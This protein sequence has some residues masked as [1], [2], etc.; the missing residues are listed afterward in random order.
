[1]TIDKRDER[2][3]KI[4]AH[5]RPT[6]VIPDCIEIK[7]EVLATT[8]EP[9]TSYH[10]IS[11]DDTPFIYVILDRMVENIDQ[12]MDERGLR[13]RVFDEDI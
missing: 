5:I 1:M 7:I 13:R 8:K 12:L 9:Y 3:E 6:R 10:I 11:K 2:W 4:Y